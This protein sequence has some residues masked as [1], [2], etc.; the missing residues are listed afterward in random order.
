MPLRSIVRN[1]EGLKWSL[2][3]WVRMIAV[4][5]LSATPVPVRRLVVVRGPM[6]ASMSITPLGVRSSAAL[7]EEPEARMHSSRD[8]RVE[9]DHRLKKRTRKGSAPRGS[10]HGGVDPA[11]QLWILL[12]DLIQ[13][14]RREEDPAAGIGDGVKRAGGAF[15]D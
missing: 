3:R 15:G 5:S 4:M 1:Q 7:P 8:I 6:P 9:A 14:R 2:S 12:S 11:I 13:G 10:G